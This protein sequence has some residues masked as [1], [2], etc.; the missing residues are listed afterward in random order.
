MRDI[1]RYRETQAGTN[2]FL[3]P[4]QREIAQNGET[5]VRRWAR[6]HG[7][8]RDGER[9]RGMLTPKGQGRGGNDLCARVRARREIASW[10]GK[11]SAVSSFRVLSRFLWPG[12]VDL[13]LTPSVFSFAQWEMMRF[14]CIIHPQS[15]LSVV[16]MF[17]DFWVQSLWR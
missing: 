3:P 8:L 14:A 9:E 10:Q 6:E 5:E 12:R 16:A 2:L 11:M 4:R 1:T 7:K 13:S 15:T 17:L